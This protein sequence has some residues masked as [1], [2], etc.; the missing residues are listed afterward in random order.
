[1][2]GHAVCAGSGRS[3]AE[4]QRAYVARPCTGLPGGSPCTLR[5]IIAASD[6]DARP[7]VRR[8]RPSKA[9]S[10]VQ[11][12]SLTCVYLAL[13]F[14]AIA[15]PSS[16]TPSSNAARQSTIGDIPGIITDVSGDSNS[17]SSAYLIA[18]TDSSSHPAAASSNDQLVA[19]FASCPL[20][21][22]SYRAWMS[23]HRINHLACG[24]S[25]MQI[26]WRRK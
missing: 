3:C 16:R 6:A 8:C 24:S 20:R 9:Q 2:A 17:P 18:S 1:M 26:G 15:A 10:L 4:N 14:A 21:T 11:S 7:P 5:R 22:R 19:R 25:R 23:L 12:V 13:G